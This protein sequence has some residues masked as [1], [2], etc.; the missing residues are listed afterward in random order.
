MEDAAAVISRTCQIHTPSYNFIDHIHN[1]GILKLISHLRHGLLQNFCLQNFRPALS[2]LSHSFRPPSERAA[3][4]DAG[5]TSRD[6]SSPYEVGYGKPP[7]RTQF[8][9]GQ[10]GNPGGRPRGLPVQRANALLLQEAYRVVA[11]KED[12]RMVPVSA[13]Q[14]ILRSQVELAINGD[15]R[16]QRDILQAVQSIERSKAYGAYIEV[17]EDDTDDDE[18]DDDETDH[19]ETDG[20]GETDEGG[21]EDESGGAGETCETAEEE[22]TGEGDETRSGGGAIL[23]A[24]AD[25]A[26]PVFPAAP[27][28]EQPEASPQVPSASRRTASA[29]RRRRGARADSTPAGG[30]RA[31]VTRDGGRP[32]GRRSGSRRSG[33]PDRA[34]TGGRAR[35]QGSVPSAAGRPCNPDRSLRRNPGPAKTPEFPDIFP[36][37]R[38]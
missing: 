23:T 27:P 9:K 7:R 4:T 29:P 34:A 38:E 25:P 19:D 15:L 2:E 12:G 1:N 21:E 24:V 22:A 26:P 33:P 5:Y 11:I 16:A 18:T 10:S 17:Y 3:M 14:A 28:H 30:T 20:C 13:M 36:V 37:L 8:R 6:T 31:D 35:S 32:E